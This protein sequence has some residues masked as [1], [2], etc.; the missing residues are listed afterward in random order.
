MWILTFPQW[1]IVDDIFERIIFQAA[2]K[3]TRLCNAFRVNFCLYAGELKQFPSGILL[4]EIIHKNY[5][6]KIH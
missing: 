6:F 2:I 5:L 3:S 4:A 1:C